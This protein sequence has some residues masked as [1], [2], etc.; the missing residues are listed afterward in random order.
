MNLSLN[1]TQNAALRVGQLVAEEGNPALRL[2]VYVNGG[3][4]SGLQYQLALD[5]KVDDDDT[6]VN[7]GT[8][9]F[10]IDPM[11]A[12]YMEGAEIDFE[13]A[14]DGARFVIKNPK[15][16]GTCGCGSSFSI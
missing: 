15:A 8:A 12:Q 7:V 1:I 10:V 16:T 2:R 14:L 13:D 4:C 6:I 9:A 11:S 3:G 5:D